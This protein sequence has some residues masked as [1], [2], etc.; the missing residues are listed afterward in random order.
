MTSENQA[1]SSARTLTGTVISNK[2]QST[3]VVLIERR[4]KH[5]KYG[6]IIRRRTKIHAHDEGNQCQM[7][8]LV[9]IKECR[10][11]SKTKAWALKEIK[12][13]AVV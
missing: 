9:V 12:K 13:A 11:I 6:K 2:M 3:I 5:P 1:S 10:P 4:V 7:G 8:D